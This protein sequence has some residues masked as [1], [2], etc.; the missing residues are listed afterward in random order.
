MYY[1]CDLKNNFKSVIDGELMRRVA[2]PGFITAAE[3][4]ALPAS[5]PPPASAGAP[6]SC[7]V[8]VDIRGAIY[9]GPLLLCQS[10]WKAQREGAGHSVPCS[11]RTISEGEAKAKVHAALTAALHHA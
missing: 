6:A 8:L 7:L 11:G 5:V 10:S 9:R 3:S 2:A 1:L 4:V